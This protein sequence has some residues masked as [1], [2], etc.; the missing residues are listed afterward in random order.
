MYFFQMKFILTFLLGTVAV[1]LTHADQKHDE[2]KEEIEAVAI[3][4]KH[5][6]NELAEML[7]AMEVEELKEKVVDSTFIRDDQHIKDALKATE[8]RIK[9]LENDLA[10]RADKDNEENENGDGKEITFSK[11]ERLRK[12]LKKLE[13]IVEEI[14]TNALAGDSEEKIHKIL[15]D[16][17]AR[18][19]QLVKE[20]NERS[21]QPEV[22]ESI[23][24]A[25]NVDLTFAEYF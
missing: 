1:L 4:S 5:L 24:I 7:L 18:I 23:P 17:D 15:K 14:K 9:N 25:E 16:M 6:A 3:E 10:E 2:L 19:T 22:D 13:N 12:P 20:S 11:K 21:Y 8:A